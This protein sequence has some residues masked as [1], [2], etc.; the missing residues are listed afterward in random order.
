MDIETYLGHGLDRS[1]WEREPGLAVNGRSNG[2]I[3]AAMDSAGD[4]QYQPCTEAHRT[5]HAATGR[6]VH[7][8][9]WS[10]S[11]VYPDTSR[12]LW[13]YTPAHFDPAATPPALMVFQDGAAYLD[14]EGAVRATRVF[15]SLIAAGDVPALVGVFLNP[16]RPAPT[17]ERA[18][19]GLSAM[20]QRSVEYDTCSN[21]YVRLLLE[22]VLPFVES[23]I[24]CRLTSDPSR[25]LICGIS[26]GGICAFNAAWHAPNAFGRVLSHCGSF[27]NIRGGHNFPYLI[28]TT[29]RKPIRA[30]LQSGRDDANIL[31]GSWPL[32][33]QQMAAALDFA[34]YEHRFVFGDGGHSLRHGGAIFADSLRWLLA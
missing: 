10:A 31:Y 16:G 6:L 30:L 20:R 7:V 19:D 32:A 23:R 4:R 24:G 5:A 29:E 2:E 11:A 34:G 15:D 33:N 22:E 26:S 28:R 25:R 17:G 8:A 21:T 13:L 12:D 27:T 1:L 3:A 9:N 14:P 18:A